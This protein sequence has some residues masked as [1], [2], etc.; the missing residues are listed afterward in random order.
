MGRAL[1]CK[2]RT[3]CIRKQDPTLQGNQHG[4]YDSHHI[5]FQTPCVDCEKHAGHGFET[6]CGKCGKRRLIYGNPRL[7]WW[8]KRDLWLE[9]HG[10]HA[11]YSVG[12][13]EWREHFDHGALYKPKQLDCWWVKTNWPQQSQI[14]ALLPAP[15]EKRLLWHTRPRQRHLFLLPTHFKGNVQHVLR[16]KIHPIIRNILPRH[17][18]HATT[19]FC[20]GWN[21]DVCQPSCQGCFGRS[22]NP[23]SG[24]HWHYF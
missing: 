1:G 14:R 4:R 3:I 6:K 13:R 15:H 9:C 7:V 2:P 22:F 16:A 11:N 5:L 18:A 12:V 23:S 24:L 21:A 19:G 20:G 10:G 17:A 8:R